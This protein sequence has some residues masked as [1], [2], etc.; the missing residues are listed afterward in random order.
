[1]FRMY[2][3]RPRP[4]PPHT[5][6]PSGLHV[7]V[8]DRGRGFPRSNRRKDRGMTGRRDRSHRL[9][10]YRSVTNRDPSL[11]RWVRSRQRRSRSF[12]EPYRSLDVYVCPIY[13]NSLFKPLFSSSRNLWND[14][15]NLIKREEKTRFPD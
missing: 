15:Q 9:P 13:R 7:Q 11:D 4:R 2:T 5:L 12:H 3:Q 6:L 10:D 1:M 14:S 8:G